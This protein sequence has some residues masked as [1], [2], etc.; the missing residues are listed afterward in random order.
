[1]DVYATLLDAG[2]AVSHRVHDERGAWLQVAVGSVTLNG[3]RLAA[4]DGAAVRG[5]PV[6]ELG[7]TEPAEVLL[8]D[9]KQGQE[10]S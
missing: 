1:V 8:F 4:G 5:E 2:Q 10:A 9:L 6:R 3:Q 7:G